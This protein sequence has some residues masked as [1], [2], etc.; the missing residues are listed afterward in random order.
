M[1]QPLGGDP[2]RLFRS[3][4][5][6]R[7][8]RLRELVKPARPACTLA[9]L[10][11]RQET[12]PDQGIVQLVG[13]GGIR[14][15]FGAHALDGLRVELAETCSLIRRKPSPCHDCLRAALLKRRIVEERIGPS[16]QHFERERR[17]LGEIA[18]SPARFSKQA[19]WSGKTAPMRSSASMRAR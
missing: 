7:T 14:P 13:I 8:P 3:V 15:G 5:S 19:I 12:K 4:N 6:R 16:R 11:F 9:R 2:K 1:W 18:R 10:V 17:R